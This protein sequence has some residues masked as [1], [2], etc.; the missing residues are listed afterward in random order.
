M[1]TVLKLIEQEIEKF[2]TTTIKKN[3]GNIV[4]LADGV[5]KVD[6]L[7]EVM[8]NEM[9]EFPNNVFGISVVCLYLVSVCV[10]QYVCLSLP[11]V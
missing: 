6:G 7:S 1:A 2:K 4:S 11:G 3:V 9:V 8:Y 5:A 10:S